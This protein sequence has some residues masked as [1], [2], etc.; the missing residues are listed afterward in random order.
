MRLVKRAILRSGCCHAVTRG[1]LVCHGGTIQSFSRL[2]QRPSSSSAGLQVRP[3]VLECLTVIDDLS[4]AAIIVFDKIGV[5]CSHPALCDGRPCAYLIHAQ[6]I[7][8]LTAKRRASH[9]ERAGCHARSHL[10]GFACRCHHAANCLSTNISALH[11]CRG[12]HWN[13]GR[14][15]HAGNCLITDVGVIHLAVF[16]HRQT[17][18]AC[19]GRQFLGVD[20]HNQVHH[21]IEWR[22]KLNPDQAHHIS[23]QHQ[24]TFVSGHQDKEHDDRENCVL[25]DL[26]QIL[27]LGHRAFCQLCHE[28][29]ALA[30]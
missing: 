24:A 6:V 29:I 20:G 4:I 1:G 25:D 9:R 8:R 13:C 14:R 27:D 3:N 17:H 12:D 21:C 22:P 28:L 2:S 11:D 18:A 10:R 5:A 19:H 30:G 26:N 16:S 23:F 15:Y 7:C